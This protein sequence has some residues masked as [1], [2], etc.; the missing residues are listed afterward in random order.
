M[1][2]KSL[3]DCKA[4]VTYCISWSRGTLVTR[5]T[6]ASGLSKAGKDALL[7]EVKDVINNSMYV[8]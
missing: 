7:N 8:V 5:R 6:S 2:H 1:I 3:C 4:S